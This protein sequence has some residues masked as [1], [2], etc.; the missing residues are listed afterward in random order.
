MELAAVI[1]G[2]MALKKP[3]QVDLYTDS[4]YVAAEPKG[5]A[6]GF[7]RSAPIGSAVARAS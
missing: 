4:V 2:L 5:K 7:L 6:D 3:C 1:Q